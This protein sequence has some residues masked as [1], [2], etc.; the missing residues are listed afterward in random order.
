MKGIEEAIAE[1][2]TYH[3]LVF[4]TETDGDRF[5]YHRI[6][7]IEERKFKSGDGTLQVG[8]ME[9][10]V[11]PFD[12]LLMV[13]KQFIRKFGHRRQQKDDD[14]PSRNPKSAT[15]AHV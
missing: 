15:L 7:G 6:R 2:G 14:Q 9:G 11:G 12:I 1:L 8:L 13:V 5:L 10:E 4:Q 3:T